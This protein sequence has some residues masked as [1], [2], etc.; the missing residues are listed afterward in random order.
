M[1]AVEN[2]NKIDQVESLKIFKNTKGYN[3]EFRMIG[4][5]EEQIARSV[6]ANAELIKQ[7]GD[8]A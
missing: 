4:N 7:Y 1:E 6:K 8:Q 5:V 3:W 2:P